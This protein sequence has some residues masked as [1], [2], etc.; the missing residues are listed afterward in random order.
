MQWSGEAIT[1]AGQ[2]FF[3]EGASCA[4]IAAE[5][6]TTTGS[7]MSC[8]HYNHQHRV[9][10]RADAKRRE[11][12][13]RDNAI[14]L[15]VRAGCTAADI[16]QR[17]GV[18]ISRVTR[19]APVHDTRRVSKEQLA[20]LAGLHIEPAFACDSPINVAL[21]GETTTAGKAFGDLAAGECRFAIGKDGDGYRFCGEPRVASKGTRAPYCACHADLAVLS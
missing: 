6:K 16:S 9:T 13:A 15:D 5:L 11:R 21:E 18:S 7:V 2:R 1:Y 4:A 8:L 19:I 17:H 20:R 10:A 14:R 3:D 12:A